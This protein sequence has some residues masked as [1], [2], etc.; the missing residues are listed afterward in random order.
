MADSSSEPDDLI[1]QLRQAIR[2]SGLALAEIARRCGKDTEGH[3]RI[4]HTQLS[5]FVRRERSLAFES[6]A[7]V[8]SAL[9]LRL[10]KEEVAEEKPRRRRKKGTA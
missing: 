9:G 8:A 5:R 10:V 1:E 3:L 4:D 6:A 7:L 2:E